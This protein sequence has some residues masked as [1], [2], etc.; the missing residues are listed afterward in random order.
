[1]TN[2]TRTYYNSGEI[3]TEL[4]LLNDEIHRTNCPAY[5][6]YYRSKRIGIKEWYMHGNLHREGKPAVIQYHTSGKISGEQWYLNGKYHRIDGPAYIGYYESNT[7]MV[8]GQFW[9]LN[10][11]RIYPEEWLKEN[12][13]EW[14]LTEDQQTEL[15]LRFA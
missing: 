11:L 14:P 15:I 5:I 10:G 7:R 13:Y 3:H 4:W 12:G 6:W 1:M 2:P 9:H 8:S